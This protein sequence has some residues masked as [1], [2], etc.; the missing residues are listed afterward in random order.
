VKPAP[1]RYLRPRTVDEAVAELARHDGDAKV[2]AGGQSLVP[3]MN[4]RLVRPQV[5][6]DVNHVP[7]LDAIEERARG[8]TI[9]AL[10]RHRAIEI[11]P[12]VRE[13]LPVLAGAAEQVGHLAI[14]NRGTFGGALVHNDP[15][16][17]FP[18]IALLLDAKIEV[19]RQS[20]ERTIAAADFFVG[21]LTTALEDGELLT[22]V[23]IPW[24]AERT[25]YGFEEL[26]RRHGDFAIAA[27]AATV[28][29]K[30]GRCVEARI[31]L[32]GVGPCAFRAYE[33][34]SV[35]R[36]RPIDVA[37]IER[38]ASAVR[39]AADPTSDL[40]AS[41]DFRRHVAGVLAERA[42]AGAWRRARAAATKT[43]ERE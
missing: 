8:L 32:G 21:P 12:V 19:K 33:A 20:R 41:A 43:E 42:I 23:E 26:S 31:S 39:D 5:L 25:G 29:V 16:A 34:E 3:M 38:A 2:L 30:D 7:G 40:H 35:L 36:D 17:E 18:M 9:G 22:S 14:R 15:A 24:L 11:S 6:V 13:R 10:V 28:T 37:L 1:F 27:A 4:Y